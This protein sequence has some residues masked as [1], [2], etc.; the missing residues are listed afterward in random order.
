MSFEDKIRNL[1]ERAIAQRSH[2]NTEEAV[3]T[4]IILPMLQS[5]GFDV[6]NALEVIP[7]FTADHGVKKGEKSRLRGKNARESCYNY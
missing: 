2:L 7:E 1:A 5:L 3:K 4:A 6:F